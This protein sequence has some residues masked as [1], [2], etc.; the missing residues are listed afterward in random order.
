MKLSKNEIIL[1]IHL[2]GI[3][4]DY[5]QILKLN[6]LKICVNIRLTFKKKFKQGL[7]LTNEVCLAFEVTDLISRLYEEQ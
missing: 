5:F 3:R 1:A 2:L 7:K 6:K 4:K